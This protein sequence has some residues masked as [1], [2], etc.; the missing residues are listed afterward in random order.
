MDQQQNQQLPDLNFTPP[1][2][3]QNAQDELDEHVQ[4][5]QDEPMQD[6]PAGSS[7]FSVKFT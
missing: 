6:N 7:H 1:L 5:A 4:D 2:D 3:Q